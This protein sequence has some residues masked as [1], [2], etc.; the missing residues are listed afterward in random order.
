VEP[1]TVLDPNL[2]HEL[3]EKT[4]PAKIFSMKDRV[5]D[6]DRT[7]PRIF[8]NPNTELLVKIVPDPQN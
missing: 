5:I 2:D 3:S 6:R 4:D 8:A 1:D 7:D